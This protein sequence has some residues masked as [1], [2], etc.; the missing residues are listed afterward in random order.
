MY[1]FSRAISGTAVLQRGPLLGRDKRCF[2]S[3]F[4]SEESAKRGGALKILPGGNCASYSCR[5]SVTD[6]VLCWNRD[7]VLAVSGASRDGV[8]EVTGKPHYL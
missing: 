7:V 8:W 3:C 6:L 4:S 1:L 5:R 2:G